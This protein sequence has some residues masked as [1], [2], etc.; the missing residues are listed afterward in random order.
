MK[1]R[2]PFHLAYDGRDKIRCWCYG[3]DYPLGRPVFRKWGYN[4]AGHSWLLPV[5][6]WWR[7]IEKKGEMEIEAMDR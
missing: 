2:A 7:W 5:G 1:I 4:V 6:A 3:L